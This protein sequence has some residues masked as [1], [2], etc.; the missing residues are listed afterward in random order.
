MGNKRLALFS[1]HHITRIEMISSMTN[2]CIKKMGM[3]CT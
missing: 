3:P 2:G 1:I